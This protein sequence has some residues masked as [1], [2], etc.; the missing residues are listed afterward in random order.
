[1]STATGQ[2]L[3]ALHGAFPFLVSHQPPTQR[4]KVIS[5]RDTVVSSDMLGNATKNHTEVGVEMLLCIPIPMAG[6]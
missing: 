4:N 1:L 5:R 3:R 6:S 2:I